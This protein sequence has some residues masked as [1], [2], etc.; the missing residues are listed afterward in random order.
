MKINSTVWTIV[1]IFVL[2]VAGTAWSVRDE[3]R[4]ET[5]WMASCPQHQP[6]EQCQAQWD[7]DHASPIVQLAAQK[8]SKP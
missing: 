8:S 7:L 3:K 2:V 6:R 4:Q 5:R 1:G